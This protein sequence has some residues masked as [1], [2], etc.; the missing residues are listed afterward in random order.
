MKHLPTSGI[1][2]FVMPFA[3]AAPVKHAEKLAACLA[4]NCQQL[5]V[6]GDQ[7]FTLDGPLGEKIRFKQVPTLH[8]LE[9]IRPV[10]WSALLWGLRLIW[11]LWRASW[12]V[13]QT[14]KQVDVIVCFLGVYYTPILLTGR[15]LGKKVISFEPSSG[16]THVKYKYRG[17][18]GEKSLIWLLRSLRGTNRTLAHI[19]GIESMSEIEQGELEPWMSKVRVVN[20][21]VD[22]AFYRPVHPLDE[23]PF[24]AGFIGRLEKVK[25]IEEFLAAAALLDGDRFSLHIVGDGPL[26]ATVEASL[27]H[28]DMKHVRFSGWADA[29]RVV[30]HL[31]QMRLLV[32]PSAGEG[33]PNAILEAM[34]CGTP[35]LASAV[36]GIADLIRHT[37]NGYLLPDRSPETIALAIEQAMDHQDLPEVAQR[38]REY[39][40]EHYSLEASTQRWRQVLAELLQ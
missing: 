30:A 32:L 15:L 2:S 14:R 5:F 34:A 22:T 12:A 37:E 38:A 36:G 23:R 11:L 20:L 29:T 13:F 28:A 19:I 27:Q 7:R 24:Q 6:V 21:Y 31:N 3:G 8:R 16:I 40:V 4:P 10:I 25:G 26:K 1:L 9:D 35:V 33:L 17:R 18:F 39:V